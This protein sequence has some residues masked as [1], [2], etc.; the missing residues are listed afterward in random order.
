MK[1]ELIQLALK[2][3]QATVEGAAKLAGTA[4]WDV[5]KE[6][7]I[8]LWIPVGSD[9]DI[10][11]A[12]DAVDQLNPGKSPETTEE[13]V[14]RWTARYSAL[15]AGHPNSAD[16]L[17]TLIG[18]ITKENNQTSTRGDVSNWFLGRTI[19]NNQVVVSDHSSY[20]KSSTVAGSALLLLIVL[21][22]IYLILRPDHSVPAATSMAPSTALATP[23]QKALSDSCGGNL[24]STAEPAAGADDDAVR[25]SYTYKVG[26]ASGDARS[27]NPGGSITQAFIA[28]RP[29]ISQ[30]SAIVGVDNPRSHAVEFQLR[31]PAGKILMQAIENESQANNNKDVVHNIS[32][33]VPVTPRQM[34]LL[35]VTNRSNEPLSLFVDPAIS[36]QVPAPYAACITGQVGSPERHVD[37]HNNILAGSVTGQDVP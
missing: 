8:Q 37:L 10:A 3:A 4:A 32:P 21:L 1:E 11:D 13:T 22:V 9:E 33:S 19:F 28:A 23:A 15:L 17:N 36:N 34:L 27:L 25:Q 31:T 12:K 24:P 35:T 20:V 18:D 30:V 26:S 5:I 16:A 29:Y 2:A 7:I 6:K 14:G